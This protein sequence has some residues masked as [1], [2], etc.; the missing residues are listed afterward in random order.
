MG[1]KLEKALR[2][3]P[4][5]DVVNV[6]RLNLLGLAPGGH[7]GR[8]IIWTKSAF[9]KLDSIYGSFEK[10][11]EKK[12]G[13]VLPRAKMVNADL[14]RNIN[15]DEVQS[16]VRPIKKEVKR[17]PMKKNPLKNLNTMLKLN[18]YAKTARRM[19]LLAE[20][21]RVKAKKEKLEK[22]RKPIAKEAAAIKAAGKAWYQTMI[23]DG[24]YTEFENFSKWLDVSQ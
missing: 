23:S 4:G 14:A 20:A 21:Q 1:A 18:P 16:A 5:V 22:K 10:P 15:S 9:E 13:Y 17:A 2:N 11:S 8:F 3:I 24:N 7:L 6:E 19:A 12:K